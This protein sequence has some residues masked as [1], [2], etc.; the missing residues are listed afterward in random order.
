MKTQRINACPKCGAAV[1]PDA[2]QGLCP[3]CVLAAAAAPEVASTATSQIPSIERLA[4][5]FPQLQILE[6][7]GRGGMGFVFKA[8][9]PQLDRLVAL[10]LL[11]DSLAHDAH[12]AERFNRE[13]R[14]LARLNHPNIVS[15]FDFGHTGAPA[16][17]P[18]YDV[19]PPKAG[20]DTGAPSQSGFYYLLMEYVDGVNLRE[21]MQAG[22]F[23]P[24]EAL[25][26]V[27]KICEA[28]QYAHEEGVLHRDIKPEN[29]LLDSK[30]RVKIADFGI[31]KI[32]GDDKP[33]ISLTATGAAL[34]TPHYMAP[35]QFEKP[36]TVDHRADIY[37]L[38]VV[39]YEL[40]TG[41]LPIGR[42][43]PPSQRTP[44]DPRVDDVVMRT[45]EKEREKRFQ[46]AGEMKTNVEHLTEAGA[47]TYQAAPPK[48]AGAEPQR[49]PG[50]T[51]VINPS[52]VVSS[53]PWSRKALW[54]AALVAGTLPFVFLFVFALMATNPG[55]NHAP[56]PSG[57]ILLAPAGNF[58]VDHARIL[59]L[60]ALFGAVGIKGTLLGRSAR[61]ETRAQ[62]GKWRGTELALFAELT[63]PALILISVAAGLANF[64]V[65]LAGIT[66]FPL[67]SI[68][69]QLI[70]L[71]TVAFAI[72]AVMAAARRNTNQRLVQRPAVEP[73]AADVIPT[74]S[75][76]A[77]WSAILAGVSLPLPLLLIV[78]IYLGGALGTAEILI[79]LAAIFL[80]G[81]A[82]TIIGWMALSDIR[83]HD[84]KLRGLPLA[85]FGAM[86]L[87]VLFLLA[88]TGAV[89]L[90][91]LA[92]IAIPSPAAILL[93]L[94]AGLLTFTI[95]SI[96]AAAHWGANRPTAQRRGVLKWIFLA[97]IVCALGMVVT[98]WKGGLKTKVFSLF[99]NDA[100]RTG[101]AKAQ[102]DQIAFGRTDTNTTPWIRFTITAVEL[103]EEKGVRWLTFEY[104]DE[105]HGECAPAFPWDATTTR[106]KAE[107]RTQEYFDGDPAS[108][109]R[110][111]I[112]E[113]RLPATLTRSEVESLHE[114]TTQNWR[115]KKFRLNLGEQHLLFAVPMPDGGEFQGRITVVRP[116]KAPTAASTTPWIRF[117]FTAVE[118]RE[119][120]GVRWLALDY[121][122]DVH[123][124]C[125]KS[126]PW[127][128]TIPGFKAETRTSEFVTDAKDGSPAVRHQRI[129]YRMPDSIRR[130]SLERLRDQLAQMLE[131]KSF[132]LELGNEKLLFEIIPMT[133]GTA[134]LLPYE[135]V[136]MEQEMADVATGFGGSLKARIKVMPP[137]NQSAGKPTAAA[138]LAF[139][140][141]F[142]RVITSFSTDAATGFLDFE[143]GEY[144]VPPTNVFRELR[145]QAGQVENNQ[146]SSRVSSELR[147]WLKE[148]GADLMGGQMI[149]VASLLLFEASP[150]T[151]NPPLPFDAPPDAFPGCG[152][153][154]LVEPGVFP[155]LQVYPMRL[156]REP[157]KSAK[158]IPFCT[159]EGNQGVMEVIG[160]T[161]KPSGVKIRYKL[162]QTHSSEAT[163]KRME[164]AARLQE[165]RSIEKSLRGKFTDEHPQ[166]IWVHQQILK[167]ESAMLELE[168]MTPI[169]PPK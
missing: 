94:P 124:E 140:P 25:A 159:R 24:A 59:T 93:V 145:T 48:A 98:P 102:P 113:Y 104:V 148:S 164:I 13:G 97:M 53:I 11:P 100:S 43:S 132:R 75:L 31:A 28:L 45:L 125:Q 122:D 33:D 82:G 144:R 80:P 150:T 117:T 128:T 15:I 73:R 108:P 131:R 27:P 65:G 29:I 101:Q 57:A 85:V 120:Q 153:R 20:E 106:L 135:S 169:R 103:R 115:G 163:A 139:G 70:V 32:V 158:A 7:I 68:L 116:T 54:G 110:R 63:Y 61:R 62:P 95:W 14:T 10:K 123:G 67:L 77:I 129:E 91:T 12:F 146:G 44:V 168:A 105:V 114:V 161:E 88:A 30:G 51:M 92:S 157:W 3:Q 118:L 74:W 96:Y 66:L 130:D 112:V 84:G 111:K 4:A 6:L 8:R 99:D 26:I 133:N 134:A 71:G 141:V 81:L 1:P 17:S 22:R 119:V 19:H 136:A 5:A 60:L 155:I 21:A 109:V 152:P 78:A 34:G 143:T 154:V 37:S 9:Q 83:A 52:D 90:A 49:G 72:W 18:A 58:W 35:E 137:L 107:T 89:T 156:W 138:P 23:S 2:P 56:A 126:F 55:N 149:N 16:S 69:P 36:A 87:P 166:L 160:L 121:L 50:G 142:E 76:K 42:F 86:T 64:I 41:E 39:F 47:G 167:L 79:A 46:S 40:L 151:H 165:L 127:E 38:G 147:D 162:V